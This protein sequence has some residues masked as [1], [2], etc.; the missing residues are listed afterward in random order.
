MFPLIIKGSRVFTVIW[1]QTGADEKAPEF[2]MVVVDEAHHV[3]I[4]Q[5][6]TKVVEPYCEGCARLLLL[7]DISQSTQEDIKYP[8]SAEVQL[9]RATPPASSRS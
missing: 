9:T 8:E 7:C 1:D 6:A 5:A 3:F 4:D 2:E